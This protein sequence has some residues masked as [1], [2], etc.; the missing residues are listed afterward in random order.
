MS[1]GGNQDRASLF[2]VLVFFIGNLILA[3]FFSTRSPIEM[4]FIVI[5]HMIW[6]AAAV[7]LVGG[8]ILFLVWVMSTS[9]RDLYISLREELGEDEKIKLDDIIAKAKQMYANYQANEAVRKQEIA[10]RIEQIKQLRA[11]EAQE[12][13]ERT[14]YLP[15]VNEDG[16]LRDNLPEDVKAAVIEA[17]I[18]EY[19]QNPGRD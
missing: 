14:S 16:T 6:Y 7:I 18:S 5:G 1:D 2:T 15:D 10:Q 8:P 12:A 19:N 4:G 9:M 3:A 17:M 13:Q 11:Q